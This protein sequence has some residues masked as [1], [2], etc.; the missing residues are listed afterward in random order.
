MGFYGP[1]PFDRASATYVWTGLDGPGFF[2]VEVEGH[3]PNF[4]SGITLVRDERFVGGLMVDV[5]GWTGPLSQGSTPYKVQSTFP[6]HVLKEI[7]VKG[8]N[9]TEVI[10]VREIPAAEADDFFLARAQAQAQTR[11]A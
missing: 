10:P 11:A 4:T 9:K 6:G 8:S 7:V 1:E 3:A 5:M 2:F